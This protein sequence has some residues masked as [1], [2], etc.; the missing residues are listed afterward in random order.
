[1]IRLGDV[2]RDGF[3]NTADINTVVKIYKGT[4][5]QTKLQLESFDIN[6]NG[7]V[8]VHDISNVIKIYKD[9][10]EFSPAVFISDQNKLSLN[11]Q[12]FP[13]RFSDKMIAAQLYLYN[14]R[15]ESRPDDFFLESEK[16]ELLKDWIVTTNVISESPLISIVY[17]EAQDVTNKIDLSGDKVIELC[18][19]NIIEQLSSSRV[20]SKYPYVSKI[21]DIVDGQTSQQEFYVL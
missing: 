13:K 7:E 5:R 6:R 17:L 18:S 9:R 14:I 11:T 2:N 16:S 12:A 4:T 1:M 21:I 3:V 8:D 19:F 20:Y 15:L 10:F